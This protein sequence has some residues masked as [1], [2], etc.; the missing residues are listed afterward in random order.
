MKQSTGGYPV[1]VTIISGFL[2]AGK[3]TLLNH[4]LHT[5][6][7]MRV[8]VLVNDFGS[9]NIDAELI[10]GVEGAET[11]NLANG[12]ICCTIRDDLLQETLRLVQQ[13][14]PPEYIVVEASGVSDPAEVANTFLLSQ[15]DTLL[16]LESILAVVDAE[17]IMTLEGA[18]QVLAMEQIGVADMVVLN[19]IDLVDDA[20]LADLR[21]W[22]Y[23]AVPKARLLETTYC[24]V[25]IDLV[26]G[27][28]RFDPGQLLQNPTGDV[29][30]H[31]VGTSHEHQHNHSLVF[32]T[33]SWFSDEPLSYKAFTNVLKDLPRSIYRAK[34]LAYF[35]DR[36][37]RRGIMH[38][39]GKRGKLTLNDIWGDEAPHTTLVFISGHGQLDHES[40]AQQLETTLAK[41]NPSIIQRVAKL[42]SSWLRD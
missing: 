30:I 15:F 22:I 31:E 17:Q 6:H 3:T 5:D 37:D 35:E 8:A 24:D 40:L 29:H 36:P 10:V 32:D 12:C 13:E 18:N 1:P 7:G 25:P 14:T 28:G 34:G 33:W 27:T 2:G 11:V 41:N 21:Q 39:V 19:K 26:L 42:A 4:I 23:D 38:M 16:Q 20:H 9:V